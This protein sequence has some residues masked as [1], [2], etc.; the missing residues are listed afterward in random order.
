MLGLC[1]EKF[2]K[3]LPFNQFV[4]KVYFYVLA[5]YKDGGDLKPVLKRFED[6]M[7]EFENKHMPSPIHNPSDIQKEIQKKR[8]KQY[9]GQEMLLKSNLVRLYGL[10]WGRS[11]AL[12]SYVKTGNL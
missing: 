10:I 5:N 12:Q 11:A 4:D 2:H 6:P 9:V 1:Y 8:V 7:N 3:K